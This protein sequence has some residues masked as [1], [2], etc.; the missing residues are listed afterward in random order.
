MTEHLTA[1]EKQAP[2]ALEIQ[3]SFRTEPVIGYSKLNGDDALLLEPYVRI[4]NDAFRFLFPWDGADEYGDRFFKT[5]LLF[6]TNDKTHEIG[7]VAFD[8]FDLDEARDLT[9]FNNEYCGWSVIR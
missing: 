1:G 2:A 9:Q 3:Y 6:V 8:D 4:R 5:C 7:F